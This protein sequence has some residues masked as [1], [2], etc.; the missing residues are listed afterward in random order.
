MSGPSPLSALSPAAQPGDPLRLQFSVLGPLEVRSGGT[1]LKIGPLKQRIALAILLCHANRVVPVTDLSEAIWGS[2]TPR[3][4]HKN[5][6]VYI[7]LLRSILFPG[8]GAARLSYRFPGYRIEIAPAELDLLTFEGLVRGGRAAIQRG[9]AA[10]GTRLLHTALKTWRGTA[11]TDLAGLPV[12]DAEA[13]RL[14][15]LRASVVEDW[16][17]A[18]LALGNHAGILDEIQEQV[19]RHPLRERLRRVQLLALSRGGRHTEALAE[20]D[21]LRVCL[22][23]ELGLEPS[24]ALRQVYRAILAGDPGVRPPVTAVK[25]QAASREVLAHTALLPPAASKFVGREAELATLA[26]AMRGGPGGVVRACV[27]AGPPGAG[28]TTLAVRACH[29]LRDV[30]RDGALLLPMRTPGGKSRTAL[31]LL[32]QFLRMTGLDGAMPRRLEERAALYRAFMASRA[33]LL[34]L[35]DT[36]DASVVPWLLPG[37]TGNGVL[38]TSRRRLVTFDASCHLDVGPFPAAEAVSFLAEMIGTRRVEAEPE[39]ALAIVESCGRLPLAVRTAGSKL[40]L[41][42]YLPLAALARRL[43]DDAELFDVL[44][45]GGLSLRACMADLVRELG[46]G[47]LQALRT[48]AALP[49]AG[50]E[51]DAVASAFGRSRQRAENLIEELLEVNA[52]EAARDGQFAL[53]RLLRAYL[54]AY[55]P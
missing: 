29:Q 14:N 26:A 37:T 49:A 3:T 11:L 9:D 35:D 43:S 54:N 38:V 1:E 32:G 19:S 40:L 25:A 27:L 34:V 45:I 47:Q 30:F 2:D 39:A 31:D 13:N 5:L 16:A 8:D 10:A 12:L 36:A 42:P 46:P 41:H 18:E 48:M 55:R 44:E 20:Y 51:L 7:S 21:D 23:R 6:Q 52:L 33:M 17:E 53:P 4:A 22:S 24:L 15:N 50:W 28:K